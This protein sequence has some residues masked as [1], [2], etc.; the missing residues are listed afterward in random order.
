MAHMNALCTEDFCHSS[1]TRSLGNIY[2]FLSHA[3]SKAALGWGTGWREMLL[4]FLRLPA[5]WTT[6]ARGPGKSTVTQLLPVHMR[7]LYISCPKAT[8]GKVASGA[9]NQTWQ[10]YLY[11]E[12]KPT[13]NIRTFVF[14]LPEKVV[15]HSLAYLYPVSVDFWGQ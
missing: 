5:A 1:A 9:G 10:K 11:Q 12:N 15:K 4:Y 8:L 2:P 7:Q 6:F 3:V 13:L 14:F